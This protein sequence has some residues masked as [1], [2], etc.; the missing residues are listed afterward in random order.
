MNTI[1]SVLRKYLVHD[2]SVS[3]VNRIPPERLPPVFEVVSHNQNLTCLIITQRDVD[4]NSWYLALTELEESY[5]V[6]SIGGFTIEILSKIYSPANHYY[7]S[8]LKLTIIYGVVDLVSP[9][10]NNNN[11][12]I[13]RIQEWT[14]SLLTMQVS[15]TICYS[16]S[17]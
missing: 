14:H 15:S 8:V 6:G 5:N 3:L 11:K 12:T 2:Y 10:R 13:R 1:H 7:I 16:F 17:I 4:T 9:A